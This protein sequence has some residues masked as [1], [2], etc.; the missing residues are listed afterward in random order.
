M[1]KRTARFLHALDED[2]DAPAGFLF[3]V[4][5]GRDDPRVVEHQ[6]IAL[7]EQLVQL[8]EAPIVQRTGVPIHD[9]QAAGA[10]LGQRMLGD[11]FG[12]QIESEIGDLQDLSPGCTGR[13]LFYATGMARTSALGPGAVSRRCRKAGAGSG[14]MM[15]S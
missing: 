2:L 8:R 6:Q 4:K 10:P 13:R 5:A 7:R 3:G 12:G 11:Q 15:R 9:E 14:N 1:R